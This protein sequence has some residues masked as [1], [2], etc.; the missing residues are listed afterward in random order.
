MKGHVSISILKQFSNKTTTSRSK[1]EVEFPRA[2]V[3]FVLSNHNRCRHCVTSEQDEREKILFGKLFCSTMSKLDQVLILDPTTE[4]RFRGE[5]FCKNRTYSYF[6]QIWNL[7]GNTR[8][9]ESLKCANVHLSDMSC[10]L[11]RAEVLPWRSRS[12]VC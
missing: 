6:Q 4:L 10:T 7:E 5:T 3:R 1:A 8:H 2:P 9:L 12:L 11:N